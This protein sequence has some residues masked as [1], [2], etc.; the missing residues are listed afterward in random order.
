MND[1]KVC[2]DFMFLRIRIHGETIIPEKWNTEIKDCVDRAT[3]EHY[4]MM[5]KIIQECNDEILYLFKTGVEIVNLRNMKVFGI[6][7]ATIKL[8]NEFSNYFTIKNH[9]WDSN[10]AW[11]EPQVVL[12]VKDTKRLETFFGNEDYKIEHY[13]RRNDKFTISREIFEEKVRIAKYNGNL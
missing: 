11:S 13:K 1:K 10:G 7:E 2:Y 8:I 12:E 9:Y 3:Y 5:C 6:E 4:K